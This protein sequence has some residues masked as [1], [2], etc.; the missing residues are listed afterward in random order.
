[1]EIDGRLH[2]IKSLWQGLFSPKA[3]DQSNWHITMGFFGDRNEAEI[4]SIKKAVEE[5]AAKFNPPEINL[6]R[7]IFGPTGSFEA[8][9]IWLEAV[10]KSLASIKKELNINLQKRG[11]GSEDRGRGF[12]PHITL[13][14]FNPIAFDRLPRLDEKL[15]LTFKPKS[16]DLMESRISSGGSVYFSLFEIDFKTG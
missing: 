13:A 2:E 3:F 6:Q 9:M 15:N 8:R 5:T 14:R 7:I 1:M 4:A 12:S 16:L 11:I 10:S